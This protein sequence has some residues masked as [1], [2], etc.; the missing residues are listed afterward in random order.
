MVKWLAGNVPGDC[1]A[2]C[3]VMDQQR[4]G[5]GAH[6]L[7]HVPH[8]MWIYPIGKSMQLINNWKEVLTQ[9]WSVKTGA[10]ASLFG[11]MQQAL[12]LIPAGLMGLTPEQS[13]MIAA[14]LGAL[15]LLCAAL[16]P[17][18]RVFDQGLVK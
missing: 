14:V 5:C 16:V 10:L 9:A 13:A 15:S 11:G 8:R 17:V 3:R 7:R 4:N 6:Y 1:L 2:F 18:V 12:P